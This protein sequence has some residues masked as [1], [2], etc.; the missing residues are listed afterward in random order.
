MLLPLMNLLYRGKDLTRYFKVDSSLLAVDI[1][2]CTLANVPLAGRLEDL[3]AMGPSEDARQSG[4][5]F[6]N[7]YSKGISATI[8][9]QR[10]AEFSIS[11]HRS[12]PFRPFPGKILCDGEVTSLTLNSSIPEVVKL[13]GEPFGNSRDDGDSA[14]VLFY[15]HTVGEVQFAFGNESGGAESIEFWYEPEL[16]REGTCESYGIQREFPAA[17]RRRLQMSER[18][19]G[20]KERRKRRREA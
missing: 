19:N 20:G 15:E 12:K 14:T 13:L 16:S 11:L 2:R 17:L 8:K 3:S 10:L 5:G 9:N 1:V 18:R 6:P 7:W 4:R